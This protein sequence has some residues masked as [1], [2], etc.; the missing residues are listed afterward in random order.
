MLQS[1]KKS[2]PVQDKADENPNGSRRQIHRQVS[3]VCGS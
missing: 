2:F 1:E 3:G